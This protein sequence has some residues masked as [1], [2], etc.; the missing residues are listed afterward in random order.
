MNNSFWVFLQSF[1]SFCL[2]NLAYI[3]KAS[4]EYLTNGTN[5][6]EKEQILQSLLLL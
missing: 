2:S 4:Y 5:D 6:M 3:D 1:N